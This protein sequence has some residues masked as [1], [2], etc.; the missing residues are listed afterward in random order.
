MRAVAAPAPPADCP[1]APQ[2][3]ESPAPTCTHFLGCRAA[4]DGVARSRDQLAVAAQAMQAQLHQLE[5]QLAG[6]HQLQAAQAELHE[7]LA[8]AQREASMHQQARKVLQHELADERAARQGAEEAKGRAEAERARLVAARGTAGRTPGR[9]GRLH[10]LW[11]RLFPALPEH[12][13]AA[14]H[15]AV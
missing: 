3:H 4:L 7:A 10:T 2:A 14:C 13:M 15:Q 5:G 11:W 8:A 1:M 9:V 6:A 12:L